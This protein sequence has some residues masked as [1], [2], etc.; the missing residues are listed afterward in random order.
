[1]GL[2]LKGILVVFISTATR[3]FK[4][5]CYFGSWAMKRVKVEARMDIDDIDPFMCT[6]LIYSFGK[7]NV[8]SLTIEGN[9]CLQI[10]NDYYTNVCCILIGVKNGAHIEVIVDCL[11][12]A[13]MVIHMTGL[14]NVFDTVVLLLLYDEASFVTLLKRFILTTWMC[15]I[16]IK[17]LIHIKC[18]DRQ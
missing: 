4:R 6:H 16:G 1:M 14:R 8:D 13:I 2:G 17:D 7:I 10:R 9:S 18:S 15:L 11:I 3:G 5:V 12:F